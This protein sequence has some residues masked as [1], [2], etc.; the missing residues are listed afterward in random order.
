M[1]PEKKTKKKNTPAVALSLRE[2]RPQTR[3]Q[4]RTFESYST[5]KNVMLTGSAGT[6]KTFV[7]LYLGLRD[8]DRNLYK[9]VIVVRSIVS[10]RDPG[11]LPGTLREKTSIF[12]APYHSVCADL[13][14][15]DDAY[16]IL[17]SRGTIEFLTTSYVRGTTLNDSVVVVD[18]TQNMRYGEI[19]SIVTR[20]GKNSRLVV[21]GDYMQSDLTRLEERRG[22]QDFLKVARNM[23]SFD[24]IEFSHQDILRSGFVKEYLIA[25]DSTELS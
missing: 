11:F 5:G 14:G 19:D 7:S 17:K 21:I 15:K 25:R 22:V 23:R 20:L 9:R 4:E 8:V 1:T 16:D 18:E 2:V 12:E 24:V 6:G 3:N 10:A 13:Y